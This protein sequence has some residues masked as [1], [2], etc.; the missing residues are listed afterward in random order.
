MKQPLFTHYTVYYK[1]VDKTN[2]RA[3]PEI[4][5]TKVKARTEEDAAEIAKNSVIAMWYNLVKVEIEIDAYTTE[6]MSGDY[7][8]LLQTT[9]KYVNVE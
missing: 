2:G 5:S 7:D 4:Y 9:M 6:A 1:R 8:H 3:L